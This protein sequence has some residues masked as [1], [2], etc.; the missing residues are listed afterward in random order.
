MCTKVSYF[1]L[2][3]LLYRPDFDKGDLLLV[4]DKAK[5]KKIRLDRRHEKYASNVVNCIE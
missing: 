3:Y 4:L 5:E 1:K 2:L